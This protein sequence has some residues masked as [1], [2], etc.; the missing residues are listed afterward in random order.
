MSRAPFDLA[1]GA[2]CAFAPVLAAFK[3]GASNIPRGV[4]T[5]N[6]VYEINFSTT[7]FKTVTIF[8]GGVHDICADLD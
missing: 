1:A 3:D 7:N 6:G 5:I 4:W 8:R 2:Y